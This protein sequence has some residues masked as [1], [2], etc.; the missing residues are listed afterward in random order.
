MGLD[1]QIENHYRKNFNTLV[2]RIKYRAGTQWNAEDIVQE[3]YLR[4]LKYA[5]TY[6]DN[7]E[8]DHWFARIVSN[9]LK[10]FKRAERDYAGLEDIGEEDELV[11]DTSLPR[12]IQLEIRRAINDLPADQKEI[13]ELH[14]VFGFEL[15]HIVQIVDKKHA[16][17]NQTIQRFK[18]TLKEKYI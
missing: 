10:D 6:R 18:K 9:T 13:V 16:T 7:L 17:I 1:Q 15:R 14:L 5:A 11:E 3:A 4:A 8:F 2:K 12:N